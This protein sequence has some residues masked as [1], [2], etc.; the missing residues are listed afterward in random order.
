MRNI[1]SGALPVSHQDADGTLKPIHAVFNDCDRDRSGFLSKT[2]FVAAM[3][4]LNCDA[5]PFAISKMWRAKHFERVEVARKAHLKGGPVV[6]GSPASRDFSAHCLSK[7][8]LNVLQLFR[9]VLM[10]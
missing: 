5:S 3:A 1:N 8:C 6:G 10:F 9:R 7:S 4:R 2:E